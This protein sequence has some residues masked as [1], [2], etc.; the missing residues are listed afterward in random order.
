MPGT[1]LSAYYEVIYSLFLNIRKIALL[2]ALYSNCAQHLRAED[3]GMGSETD[4]LGLNTGSVILR[5]K[6]INICKCD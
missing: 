2:S 1:A 5:T 4:C 6:W 3:E